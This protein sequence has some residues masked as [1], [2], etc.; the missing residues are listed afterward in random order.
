MFAS[1]GLGI[2]LFFSEVLDSIECSYPGLCDLDRDGSADD[3]F[4][5]AW[6]QDLFTAVDTFTDTYDVPVAVNEFGLMRWEPG[7]D[8]FMDDEMALMEERGINYALWMWDP[9]WYT[10]TQHLNAFNF[11]FGPDPANTTQVP[12][13]ALQ[14]VIEGYWGQNTMYPS[15]ASQEE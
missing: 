4:D 12:T 1:S 6:L 11:R 14:L 10:W 3:T 8:Q 9:S 13:N 2:R 15:V 5:Q 7:G